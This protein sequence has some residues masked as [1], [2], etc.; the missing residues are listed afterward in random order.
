MCGMTLRSSEKLEMTGEP[1]TI[2]NIEK[3]VRE[4]FES[5]SN[6]FKNANYDE[7]G[8]QV[9]NGAERVAGGLGDVIMKIFSAF[10]KV[11]GAIILVFS[12]MS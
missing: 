2:S 5:V 1:V 12:A 4:E 9:K 10:A 6:K 7:M 11:L 3:K 8:N